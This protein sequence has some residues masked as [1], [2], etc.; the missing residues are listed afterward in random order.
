MVYPFRGSTALA[1]GD[2]ANKYQLRRGYRAIFPDIYLPK[3]V[4][5]SLR[6]ATAG[7]WLWSQGQSV[8]AGSAAAALHGAK[9]VPDD[10]AIDLLTANPRAPRGIVTHRDSFEDDE[11]TIIGGKAVTTAVRTAFDIG[12]WSRSGAVA[13][14]DALG[15]ATGFSRDE[16]HALARRHPHVRHLRALENA[17]DLYDPARNRRRRPGCDCS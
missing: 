12:R 4:T 6:L 9:W 5:P 1:A 8:I 13:R 16:V 17:L 10:I 14:L 2:I 7:A 11:V 3:G 15:N